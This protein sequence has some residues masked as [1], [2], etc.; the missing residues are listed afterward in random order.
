[1]SAQ[2]E[3]EKLQAAVEARLPDPEAV[4]AVMQAADRY[5]MAR[6]AENERYIVR[7]F[8]DELADELRRTERRLL[9]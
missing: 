8:Q 4:K 6:S 7:E 5:A 2:T 9:G 3:R 1:V